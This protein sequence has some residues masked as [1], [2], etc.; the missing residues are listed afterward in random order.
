MWMMSGRQDMWAR[1]SPVHMS[2][3]LSRTWITSDAS[4]LM[5]RWFPSD[6]DRADTGRTVAG[7][8]PVAGPKLQAVKDLSTVRE[9]AFIKIVR[10]V[11]N[12]G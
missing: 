11:G 2:G 5:S 3:R 12:P 10:A 1:Q 8:V 4:H 7:G 9:A 6:G